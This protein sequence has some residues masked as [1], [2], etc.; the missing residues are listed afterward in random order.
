M[1]PQIM[2]IDAEIESIVTTEDS[3]GGLT[4]TVHYR[5]GASADTGK[6]LEFDAGP[7]GASITILL[8]EGRLLRI[9]QSATMPPSAYYAEGVEVVLPE[10]PPEVTP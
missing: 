5:G 8:P 7:H 10:A 3:E 9:T 4:A 1:A 6:V 2:P